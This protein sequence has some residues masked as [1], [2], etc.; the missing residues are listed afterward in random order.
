MKEFNFNLFKLWSPAIAAALMIV[1]GTQS[2][3]KDP[4]SYQEQ[5]RSV[6]A[7]EQMKQDTSL[8]FA[9]AALEKA[10][11]APTLN[12]YGP[13]TFF[14]PDNKAFRKFFAAKGKA[15]LDNFSA[16][17]IKFYMIYHIMQV[18]LK[19]GDF[20]QGPQPQPSGMG[21][22]I[23]LDISKG[24]KFNT[25]ANGV[26]N[27]YETDIEYANGLVHKMDAVLDP[28]TLTIGQFL[29]QNKDKYSI[30]IAGLKR[31]NLW[32][33]LSNLTDAGG[34]RIRLTFFAENNEVL[35]AAGI[36]SFDSWPLDRLDTLLRYHMIAGAGFSSTYTRKTDAKSTIG[37]EERWDS[38]I[39]SL[40]K[41]QYLYFDL[42]ATKFINGV[43][44]FIASDVIMR[45]GV[46]HSVD[47]HLEFDPSIKR[48]Q[49]YHWFRGALPTTFAYGIPGIN[50]NQQAAINGSGNWRTFAENN[51]E[52]L[53]FNPDGVNDS[54]VTIIP[55][56]RTG[57][58]RIEV[59]YKSGGR[60]DYQLMYRNDLIGVPV[61]MGIQVGT[62]VYDQ[63]IVIG[64]Y[65]FA[66][67][68]DK[69]LNFVCT[70][71]SGFAPENLVL[72]P[73]Y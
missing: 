25:I 45:N 50:S 14:A 11:M 40:N 72:T 30:M 27:V 26:A 53:F 70:R 2:C 69:R 56:I 23:S 16:D 46:L 51:R 19:S 73:V 21:D 5:N 47:K 24:F 10:K 42:A 68:G 58:Y 63:R 3:K 41:Q 8:S 55:N 66:T 12:T 4:F 29:D 59:N 37:I 64:T 9:V 54:M 62:T 52:F 17:E 71:V 13:F 33:T 48:T 6:L 22:F 32:D 34:Q 49:I 28:P 60:G 65:N 38:T 20:V 18:R 61:N 57:K 7:Y 31:A 15:G 35:Q 67:S 1:I 36:T 43:A 44:N 39:L